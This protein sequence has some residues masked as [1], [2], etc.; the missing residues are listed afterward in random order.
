M[1]IKPYRKIMEKHL[2]R[3]LTI[4]EIVH[5]IDRDHKN[6]NLSNLKLMSAEEH[7]SLHHAGLKYNKVPN[8]R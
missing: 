4:F 1:N 6:N 8:E 3:K 5:H 2:G 7:T